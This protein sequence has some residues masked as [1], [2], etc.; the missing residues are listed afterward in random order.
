[1]QI[2]PSGRRRSQPDRDRRHF[3][4]PWDRRHLLILSYIGWHQYPVSHDFV[5]ENTPRGVPNSLR[6]GTEA[7]PYKCKMQ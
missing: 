5:V 2:G 6:D 7:A 4:G 1:M 3:V